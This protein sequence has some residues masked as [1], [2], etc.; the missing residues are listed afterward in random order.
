MTGWKTFE[1]KLVYRTLNLGDGEDNLMVS[2]SSKNDLLLGVFWVFWVFFLEF[3]VLHQTFYRQIFRDKIHAVNID[4][5]VKEAVRPG[6][7]QEIKHI[8]QLR[9]L[10]IYLIFLRKSRR[11]QGEKVFQP[12]IHA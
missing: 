1:V 10:N 7:L 5:F 4:A 8:L 11:K 6:K 2:S 9:I 3:V 12:K